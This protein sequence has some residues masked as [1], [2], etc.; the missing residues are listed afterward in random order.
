MASMMH[1]FPEKDMQASRCSPYQH[2]QQPSASVT[3]ALCSSQDKYLLDS[4]YHS[5]FFF[6]KSVLT[7]VSWDVF[8]SSKWKS[9]RL[10]QKE[11]ILFY[12]WLEL[13]SSLRTVCTVKAK[14]L[15]N[16]RHCC[17]LYD[18]RLKQSPLM[19]DK[20]GKRTLE[21]RTFH[22]AWCMKYECGRVISKHIHTFLVEEAAAINAVTSYLKF[23]GK[24]AIF[25]FSA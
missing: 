15:I 23:Q 2:P 10:K 6:S 16:E 5:F 20:T 7:I 18:R 11:S 14:S 21:S 3:Y 8:E 19:T 13:W 9:T 4:L 25:C 24:K 12:R 17:A 22:L 1:L